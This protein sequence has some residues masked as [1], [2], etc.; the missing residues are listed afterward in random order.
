V[1]KTRLSFDFD[2]DFDLLG[3]VSAV[4]GYKLAWALNHAL[5]IRFVKEK[6]INIE[7]LANKNIIISN[8]IFRTTYSS[9]RL[10]KNRSEDNNSRGMVYLLPELK[11][12]DY[13]LMVQDQG[14]TFIFRDIAARLRSVNV[15]QFI[16]KIETANLKSKE[17]LIF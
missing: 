7:F 4:K 3:L 14:D 10:L 2:Y 8:F 5:H 15:I 1:K 11:E 9:L 13:F 17:N 6:D 16:S 12:F